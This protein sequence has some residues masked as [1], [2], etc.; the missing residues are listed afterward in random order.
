M[1]GHALSCSNFTSPTPRRPPNQRPARLAF[2][3]PWPFSARA[4]WRCEEAGSCCAGGRGRQFHPD[5]FAHAAFFHGHAI[6]Y[7][8][9]R[10]RAFVV[11]DDD[12]LALRN[13]TVEHSNKTVDVA[14]I[15]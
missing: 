11:G 8:C 2:C 1:E 6:K 3:S 12:E 13:E 15:Q 5:Q 7:V 4:N 9:L 14:L 10:D